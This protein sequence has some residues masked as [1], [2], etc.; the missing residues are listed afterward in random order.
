ME[1][2]L[3]VAVCTSPQFYDVFMFVL[4]RA[5]YQTVTSQLKTPHPQSYT[6]L[7]L[8]KNRNEIKYYD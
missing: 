6:V 7:I 4:F 5:E 2:N 3:I 1:D 8:K